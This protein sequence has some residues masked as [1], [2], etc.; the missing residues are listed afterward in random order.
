M[1]YSHS[2]VWALG[3]AL[4]CALGYGLLARDRRGALVVAALV[5]SHWVLDWI[6]HEPDMP[7]VPGGARYGL[8]LWRSLP[9]TL[10]TELL[11]FGVGAGLYTRTTRATGRVG[12]VGWPVLVGLLVVGFLAAT[13]GAPPPDIDALVISAGVLI[14]VII[15]AAVAIDRQRPPRPA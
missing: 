12:R 9:A 13:L 15:G 3:W 4:L 6:A 1:P 7:L 14:V 5:L 10:A 8:G 2:L 11:M